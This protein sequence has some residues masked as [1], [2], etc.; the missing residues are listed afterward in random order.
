VFGSRL[1]L[2][3]VVLLTLLL[4]ALGAARPTS[5]AA[6]ETRYV[7]RAG[8]TLWAIAESHYDGDPREAVWRIEQRNHLRGTA[9]RP[10]QK[11]VLP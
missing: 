6:P 4:V 5:G 9:I 11:L 2:V 8:D 10:G 1:V 7:V 3:G